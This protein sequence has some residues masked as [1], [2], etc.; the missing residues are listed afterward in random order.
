[1]CDS[2]GS[3]EGTQK[4]KSKKSKNNQKQCSLL[5][6]PKQVRSERCIQYGSVQS[7]PVKSLY[8]CV[9]LVREEK[10]YAY[11]QEE[12]RATQIPSWPRAPHVCV[13]HSSLFTES[14][15]CHFPAL[16]YLLMAKNKDMKGLQMRLMLTSKIAIPTSVFQNY[17]NFS[18]LSWIYST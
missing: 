15:S 12:K 13:S 16:L 4:N 2:F 18:F 7:S 11:L 8:T 10:L 3:W 14:S 9:A 5:L 17:L 1:M 6:D